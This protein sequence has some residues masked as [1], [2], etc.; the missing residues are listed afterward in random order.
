[1]SDLNSGA[2]A[3]IRGVEKQSSSLLIH[4]ERLPLVKD[5]VGEI[6]EQI[7]QTSKVYNEYD[8]TNW[9]CA[10]AT[11]DRGGY[12]GPGEELGAERDQLTRS[13]IGLQRRDARTKQDHPR[14]HAIAELE[15]TRRYVLNRLRNNDLIPSLQHTSGFQDASFGPGH[16]TFED[17]KDFFGDDLLVSS[18]IVSPT[19]G[20][21]TQR[22]YIDW[23]QHDPTLSEAAE[24]IGARH[25]E[26]APQQIRTSE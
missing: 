8:R 14:E 22:W 17:V 26:P 9:E 24:I 18:D 2:E 4:D 11:R 7:E 10:I 5:T 16:T 13:L 21:V 15:Q 6:V 12:S 25:S 3:E 20:S 19:D 1:M 23:A